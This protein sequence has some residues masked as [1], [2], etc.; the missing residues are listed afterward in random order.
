MQK[1][2]VQEKVKCKK[3]CKQDRVRTHLPKHALVCL[4]HGAGYR[5]IIV[6]D[7]K[8]TLFFLMSETC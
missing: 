1:G 3:G 4:R 5:E 8:A 2:E 6:G 7:L